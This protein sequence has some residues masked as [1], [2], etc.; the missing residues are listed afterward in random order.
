MDELLESLRR[1]DALRDR[2]GD[3]RADTVLT[4][5]L[6]GQAPETVSP[7]YISRFPEQLRR[8]VK[9]LG[10]EKLYAHQA[11]AIDRILSG[12]DIVIEAPTA[13]GKTLSFNIPLILKLLEDPEARVLMVHPMKAVAHDQ[14]RQF[15][16]LAGEL[17]DRGGRRLESWAFDGDVDPEHRRLLKE[18]PPAVLFTN[19]D[20]LHLSFLGWQDQWSKFL[21]NLRLV[22]LDEIHE[23]RGYF[24]TN[25][26]LLLR[27][28]FARLRQL[29]VRPQVILATA[30]CGNPEE[31]A[32]RL[33][34]R[35]C[36]L[37]KAPRDIRPE[38]HF[39]FITPDI[40]DYRFH[41]IFLL[42]IARAALACMALDLN[43]L[44]FCPS[45]RFAEEAARRAKREAQDFGLNPDAIAPY[46]SGYTADQRREIE[47]GLRTGR[48]K[49]VFTTNA[50]EI[51]IDIGELD[52]CLLAGFPDN[53]LSAW[54]R[55]GRVGR[56]W[57]KKT[58]VL[59]YALNNP[60]D[61]F[62]ASNIDAFLNKP[63]DHILIG[64]DNEELMSRHVSYLIHE[65]RGSLKGNLK[66]DLGERFFDIA[67]EA[68]RN[69]RPVMHYPPN[70]ARLSIR[71]GSGEV[72]KLIYK[73]KEIGEISDV[74]VF[75]EAYVGAI[76]NH[77]GRPYLVS[78]HGAGKVFLEDAEPH[79]RT[80]GKFYTTL[81][82]EEILDGFRY[83]GCLEA[84]YGRLTVSEHFAGFRVIDYRSE[85]VVEERESRLARSS[86]V[87]GFWIALADL[88][89]LP[90]GIDPQ[91]F[92]NAE[93]LLRVGS[94]FI[95]PC[96]RHDVGTWTTF[97]DLP[98]IYLYETVEG[99]IGVAEEALKVWPEIIR[100][101]MDIA[102]KCTCARGCP[103]CLVPPRAE[104]GEVDKGLA[105]A[106]G[107]WLCQMAG[108][109]P[110]E[111]YDIVTHSWS[112]LP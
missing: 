58:Y 110:R 98:A 45:R 21:P 65:C 111:R 17:R 18:N 60:F 109:L 75:R 52:V 16:D 83:G 49:A 8:A 34:G 85:E 104:R 86:K 9:K 94:P 79:L 103:S 50:L 81:H 70:Y 92:S 74:H 89:A 40:P 100:T 27:R 87:R 107:Q 24:G 59:F 2:Q 46:R 112:P 54:Q 73:K 36:V 12:D 32:F 84:Y 43:T 55:I 10:I 61:R 31:H 53:V 1:F 28:F 42:R 67:R 51:G 13:A 11:E 20:M 80:E 68:M 33:T 102:R 48:Y 90:A 6:P 64:V 77:L 69:R 72:Y 4:R 38:R 105:I 91:A 47:E 22:I 23:Y 19:P 29:G 56:S 78:A 37:V 14:R 7:D 97:K 88:A 39:A 26:A 93:Q 5:S 44:I 15:L 71:G 30:T 57:D 96:D 101:G 41:D 106:I 35:R 76:Y 62:F 63:L 3:G 99:G 108:V 66:E 25:V 82:T 95:I